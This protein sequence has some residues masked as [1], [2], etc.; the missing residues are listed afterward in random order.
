M[1]RRSS[2]RNRPAGEEPMGWGY[3]CRD[4]ELWNFETQTEDRYGRRATKMRKAP[5]WKPLALHPPGRRRSCT[6]LL[7]AIA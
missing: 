2:R 6:E 4:A 1:D 5:G 3:A 7:S